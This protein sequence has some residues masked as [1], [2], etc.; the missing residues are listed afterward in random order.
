MFLVDTN[1]FLEILLKRDKKE[2]CKKFLDNSIGNLNITD[3]SLHSI[4]VILFRYGKEEVF[5]KFVEDIMP[6]IKPLSLPMELYREVVNVRK[7]LN[8]DF[9]DAYQYSVAKYYGLK[10]VT[11]DRDFERIKDLKILFL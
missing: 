7:S 11:M 1:V 6:N 5:R 4:G 3:F 2:D 9:D 8:L 10:V